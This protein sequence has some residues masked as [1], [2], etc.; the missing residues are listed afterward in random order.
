MRGI[1]FLPPS[2]AARANVC[3][4]VPKLDQGGGVRVCAL[5]GTVVKKVCQALGRTSSRTR[6]DPIGR[7][8]WLVAQDP[9]NSWQEEGKGLARSRLGVGKHAKYFPSMQWGST[10]PAAIGAEAP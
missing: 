3:V 2:F 4:F 5:P 8:K 7:S 10:P 1:L 9:L 6:S